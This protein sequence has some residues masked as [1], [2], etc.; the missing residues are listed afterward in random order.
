MNK[1]YIQ[2]WIDLAIEDLEV[3]R[4][5]YEN[6]KYSNSFYHFQQASEKGLKAYAF[7]VKTYTSE[8]DANHT[9]HY[10]L[11]VFVDSANERQKE[12]A[13]LK[14]YEFEKIIGI[15]NLDEYSNNL[16]DG[17]NSLP[18]KKE[19]FEYSND[20][21]H[22]IL[23]TICEL[24]EYDFELPNGFKEHLIEKM[25]LIFDLIYKLNP[26]KADETK[27]EF[28]EL[29]KDEKQL[30]DFIEITKEHLNNTMIENYY[31]LILYYSNLISHNHNNK[32]RYPEIDFNPLE[33]YNLSCPIVQKL[34]G[35]SKYLKSTLLQLKK[36]NDLIN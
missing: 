6:K 20:I 30:N 17:L 10:T 9:G 11:K 5:L 21:L 32:S 27:K 33:D 12:I 36:W 26:E 1:T 25:D 28:N 23:K 13:F 8:K 24:S 35:F 7:M 22:E 16:E 34:P 18:Q 14:D 15:E 31:V 29:L 4:I 3:S 2:S 19:I